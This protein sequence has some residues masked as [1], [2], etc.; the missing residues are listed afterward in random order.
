MSKNYAPVD[1]ARPV[2]NATPNKY[3]VQ[4][5]ETLYSIAWH[6]D[7]DYRD[8]AY[9]NHLNPPY[10]LREG[11]VISLDL[12]QQQAPPSNTSWT[13]K[14]M[15]FEA[16]PSVYGKPEQ[17]SANTK[18]FPVKKP[19]VSVR[20]PTPVPK[21]TPAVKNNPSIK[22]PV[23]TNEK[24]HWIWPAKGNI[25][26]TYSPAA[27][28]KGVDIAG[29]MGEPIYAAAPGKV[30]YSGNGLRGYGNLIIIKHNDEFL[31]AYAH[32]Q[33]LL[34]REGQEVKAG[35]QIATMGN[36]ESRKVM[37]HFEIREAGKS[38]NPLLYVKP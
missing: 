28:R 32:N 33:K 23:L 31:S 7:M 16:A 10:T 22:P 30:A 36:T 3:I 27:G 13:S 15:T 17:S 21:T 25:V 2:Y 5:D 18:T 37:L 34:V 26:A 12:L 29:K 1:G 20:A 35:Q 4:R 8:L 19:V 9:V 14:P 24:I 6:Y 11:Q 38:V